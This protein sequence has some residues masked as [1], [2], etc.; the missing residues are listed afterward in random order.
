MQNP[1]LY[2]YTIDVFHQEA[3]SW[4]EG[5]V[6]SDDLQPFFLYLSYTVP[7]AGGWGDSPEAPEQGNP[8]PTD[9]GYGAEPWPAVEK[10]HAAVIT[11]PWF[12]SKCLFVLV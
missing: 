3:M 10:D 5:V 8:V 11:Y 6:R 7:H 2:N 9:M 12:C 1:E 4:M